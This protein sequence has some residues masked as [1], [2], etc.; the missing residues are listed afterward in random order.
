MDSK[1]V[2]LILGSDSDMPKVE[3]TLK[4]LTE[5]E[6]PGDVPVLSAH[7]SPDRVVEFAR[8]AEERG[9]RVILAAAGGAAHLAGVI[10]A[11]TNLPVIG[12]PIQTDALGG[13]DSLYSTVQ[14]PAGVPVATMAIGG[15]GA[16]NAGIFAAQILAIGD[17]ALKERLK[18][19]KLAL[20][21][22]VGEKNR[23]VQERMREMG[24]GGS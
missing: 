24:W 22:S 1:P 16:T 19:R 12:I 5:L 8:S 23:R 10:A 9:V 14:M 4:A 13:V 6:I 17:T 21:Q 15:G 7:R 18:A 2:A 11:H 20:E 3:G